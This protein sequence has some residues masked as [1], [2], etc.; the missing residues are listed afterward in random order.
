VNNLVIDSPVN[1]YNK[2]QLATKSLVI[3]AQGER[4][5]ISHFKNAK[6]GY[7][8]LQEFSTFDE[9]SS[10]LTDLESNHHAFILRGSLRDG[11]ELNK[12]YPR[13][14]LLE[15][16][17]PKTVAFK[18]SQ[19]KWLGF[20]IDKMPLAK[21]GIDKP[22][23]QVDIPATIR[24]VIDTY[25]PELAN[26]SCHYQLSSSCGWTDST[27]LSCHLFFVLS[28]LLSNSQAKDLVKAINE[29]AGF[30]IFDTSLY[31]AVQPHFTA[32]PLIQAPA[33][34][35][36]AG[37]RSGVIRYANDYLDLDIDKLL[38]DKP[39]EK[40]QAKP[41]TQSQSAKPIQP[42]Y[43]PTR[44]NIGT[45][46]DWIKHFETLENL[47]NEFRTFSNWI[48]AHKIFGLTKAEEKLVFSAL[49]K[50]PRIKREPSRL[51]RFLNDGEYRNLMDSARERQLLARRERYKAKALQIDI[52]EAAQWVNWDF[53]TEIKPLLGKRKI[54]LCDAPMGT[55]KTTWAKRT[56]FG[57]KKASYS[58]FDTSIVITL[59]RFLAKLWSKEVKALEDYEDVKKQAIQTKQDQLFNLS[60]CLN[61]I[62][63]EGISAY[64]PK[65]PILIIDECE[66]TFEAIFS[67][68]IK[69]K[70]RQQ[71]LDQLQAIID[72]AK[73]IVLMQHNITELTLKFLAYF[74]FNRN[75]VVIAK[76]NYYRYKDT[77]C[78]FHQSDKGLIEEL[79]RTIKEGVRCMVATNSKEQAEK[80]LVGLKKAF[81]KAGL[82]ITADNSQ[83]PN[84][85][86]FL[87]KPT[88]ESEK[89]WYVIFSP[90]MSVGVS[91]ENEKF[92]RTFGFFSSM[93]GNTP[94]DCAQ[95][96]FRSRPCKRV[97]YS[98][99]TRHNYA[100]T[101]PME[102]L[103]QAVN[104]WDFC[105][106]AGDSI[107]R[108]D[109]KWQI[110]LTPERSKMLDL[111]AEVLAKKAIEGEDFCGNLYAELKEGMGCNVQLVPSGDEKFEKGK[112]ISG[113]ACEIVKVQHKVEKLQAAKVTRS[114][115]KEMIEKNEQVTL[116]QRRR[117]EFEDVMRVDIDHYPAFNLKN[118]VVEDF[119]EYGHANPDLAQALDDYDE[120]RIKKKHLLLSE[121]STPAPE[122]ARYAKFLA[123][124]QDEVELKGDVFES[125]WLRWHLF[126]LLLPLVGLRVNNWQLEAIEGFE[127]SYAQ[128]L[129]NQQFMAF[130]TRHAQ[131]LQASGLARFSGK[132]PTAKTIG[133]W[134]G[135]LGLSPLVSQK[136][137]DGKRI[138]VFTWENRLNVP[139]TRLLGKYNAIRDRLAQLESIVVE[140][141][142]TAK[143]SEDDFINEGYEGEDF[144]YMND[145]FYQIYRWS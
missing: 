70:Q 41:K 32:A 68:T 45:L 94:S 141:N 120:G 46:D 110:T 34:D 33:I 17:E 67:G 128:V 30:E 16:Y 129:A 143:S 47:H 7:I 109:G 101:E 115:Y 73:L 142:T 93:A 28:K 50:S 77:P 118:E 8:T 31:Q 92:T 126:Q 107:Q 35:P 15:K 138:K 135:Q 86:A 25:A 87:G 98:V 133:Y 38:L 18:E 29:R 58:P 10:L 97:D 117:F 56:F 44:K 65:S 3:N 52:S 136:R 119:A 116:P 103:E 139:T 91:V 114:Q 27:S 76:N 102:Y 13:R 85:K 81:P 78:Y 59:L 106:K 125:F 42:L 4:D 99:D 82:M 108:I 54:L 137:I 39:V 113:E 66:A 130:C 53:E 140:T 105:Q 63:N 48:Y 127:F 95:M 23:E 111:H 49:Q 26:V 22:I 57:V 21:L 89:Y 1:R 124:K 104:N 55:G 134:L 112:A 64:L 74:G 80:L 79:H 100:P 145:E 9:F 62:I 40:N 72:D 69:R 20:D 43:K 83:F 5:K 37:K 6:H 122:A 71:V 131:A 14:K 121:G 132:K 36:I 90:S 61:S 60:V 84:Q 19:E 75:D 2:P 96:L 11:I 144:S 88:Q 123:D 12:P 24:L 51:E